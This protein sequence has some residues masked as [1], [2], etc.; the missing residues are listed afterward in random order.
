MGALQDDELAARWVQLGVWSPFLRLHSNLNAFNSREPWNYNLESQKT[1]TESLQLRHRLLP[2][3][4]SMAVRASLNGVS[5]VEPMY[6]DHPAVPAAYK[7]RNQFRFGSEL[8]VSPITTPREKSTV[9]GMAVTWLP[10]GRFVDIFTGSVY[11]GDRVIKLHR[12]LDK[13]PVLAREGAI[14]PF[15][16]AETL[17][18]GCPIPASIEI[19]LVVGANGHFELVEDDGKGSASQEIRFSRTSISYDDPTGTLTIDPPSRPLIENREWSIAL[20]AYTLSLKSSSISATANGKTVPINTKVGNHGTILSLGVI[21]STEAIVIK[22]GVE[23]PQLNIT[24]A[25]GAIWSLLS[26][27][28]IGHVTK[29]EV[30]TIVDG[31]SP[32]KSQLSGLEGLDLDPAVH[33]AVLEFL[34]ADSR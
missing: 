30:W 8:F 29:E 17:K 27:A 15:D 31:D 1:I 3:L 2:Y 6:Y 25:K 33:G 4:Y 23:S 5:L 7:Y 22:L 21:P 20:V 34:L 28:Q 24:D 12:G 26:L 9:M 16:S 10:P 19:N 11:D 32:L 14:V 18:N 13:C